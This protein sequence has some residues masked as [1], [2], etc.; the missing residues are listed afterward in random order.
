ME[1]ASG[2][3]PWRRDDRDA[4]GKEPGPQARDELVGDR[5]GVTSAMGRPPSRRASSCAPLAAVY[6][7]QHD[8][9]RRGPGVHEPVDPSRG[10][11]GADR[12]EAR[13]GADDDRTP[14]RLGVEQAPPRR[15]EVVVGLGLGDDDGPRR[16][17][18]ERVRDRRRPVLAEL[19]ERDHDRRPAAADLGD[20]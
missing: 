15:S 2:W 11:A 9:D 18:L 16:G 4:I 14:T 19:V 13:R 10:E 1:T 5:S 6:D 3:T 7:P 20:P 17:A 8:E 12:R